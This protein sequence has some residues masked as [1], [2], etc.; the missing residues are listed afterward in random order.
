MAK[1]DSEGKL[2]SA[3]QCAEIMLKRYC[4]QPKYPNF[5]DLLG[6]DW[7]K[8]GMYC[9]EYLEEAKVRAAIIYGELP[10]DPFDYN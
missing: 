8:A 9:D 4:Q 7:V 5:S 6:S 1:F 2:I 3:M 10:F